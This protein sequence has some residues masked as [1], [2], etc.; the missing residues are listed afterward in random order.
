[1]II[2]QVVALITQD[3]PCKTTAHSTGGNPIHSTKANKHLHFALSGARK[4][5]EM[6]DTAIK[7]HNQYKPSS[8]CFRYIKSKQDQVSGSLRI[9]CFE[10]LA[11]I[12]TNTFGTDKLGC[13]YAN[14]GLL[15]RY[16]WTVYQSHIKIVHLV[17]G[18]IQLGEV[19]QFA[20]STIA[21]TTM[22]VHMV[23][24]DYFPS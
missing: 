8:P 3:D 1:M 5:S 17:Y 22:A 11:L 12:Y 24:S 18:I 19:D 23:V 4:C 7:C 10:W 14:S 9:L 16:F 2:S 13:R 6:K 21:F 15:D 20:L